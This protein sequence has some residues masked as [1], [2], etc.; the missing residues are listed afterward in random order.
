MALKIR[1][2]RLG[3]KGNPFYRIVVAES[4]SPRDGK[5]IEVLGTFD[6]KGT[7]ADAIKIDKDVTLSWVAKGAQPTDTVKAVLVKAGVIPAEKYKPK[8]NAKV[9]PPKTKT[10]KEK[11]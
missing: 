7:G 9:S 10:K 8:A 5:F 1:L 2:T 6:P 11:K 4:R 3:D